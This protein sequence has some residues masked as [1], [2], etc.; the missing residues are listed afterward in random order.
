MV[1]CSVVLALAIKEFILFFHSIL[2]AFQKNFYKPT[3]KSSLDICGNYRF[4]SGLVI[5]Q[6]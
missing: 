3:I 5:F 2:N 6:Q 1:N 4:L